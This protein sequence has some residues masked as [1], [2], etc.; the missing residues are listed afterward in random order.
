M[1]RVGIALAAVAV[2]VSL[3][4]A[5]AATPRARADGRDDTAW[6]QAR[7]DASGGVVSLPKL[8]GGQCY[9]TRG[10]WVS[11]DD[12]QIVS[13]GACITALGPGPV[14]LTSQDGDPVPADAVFFVNH[15]RPLDAPPVRVTIRGLRIV[16]P[17]AADMF[18]I[19]IFAHEVIVR[20]V[21]VTGEPI[22]AITIGGRAN[23]DGY[24]GRVTITGCRLSGATR[25]VLSATAVIGLRVVGSRLTGAS[26]THTEAPGG[27]PYGNPGAGIDLEPGARGSPALDVRF[28]RNTISGNAGPGILVALATNLGR[29]VYGTDIAIV[30]NRIVGNGVKDTP[31]QHGGIVFDGGQDGGGGR[32]LVERNVIRGNRGA[33]L[34]GRGDVNLVVVARRND[35]KGNSGGA[36]RG[37]KLR[38]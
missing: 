7:L 29:M 23:G 32:V 14:R 33:G 13:N 27:K 20:G 24:A 10:L 21:T 9:A 12:T 19:G 26:D 18:G 30:G 38:G 8:P 34:Q 37:L 3:P 6:L 17:R 31:P 35:L 11:H 36:V 4:A 25:N 2:A 28:E 5:S 15:S 22:D 1:A 16:V